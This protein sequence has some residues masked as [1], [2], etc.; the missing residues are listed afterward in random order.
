MATEVIQYNNPFDTTDIS[1]VPVEYGTSAYSLLA[2]INYDIDCYD[3]VISKNNEII[4]CDFVIEKDDIVYFAVVPKGGGGGGGKQALAIVAMVA[5]SIAAPGVGTYAGLM[6]GSMGA[7][8]AMIIGG[9]LV[10]QIGFTIVGAMIVSSVFKPK[11]PDIGSSVGMQNQESSPTYG[12]DVIGNNTAQGYPIPILYGTMKITPQYIGKYVTVNNDKQY[13]S[14]LLA[15]GDGTFDSINDIRLNGDPASNYSNVSIETR[16]GTNNQDLLPLWGETWSDVSVNKKVV[17]TSTWV[18]ATTSGDS[19]TEL[20]IGVICPQGLY[21]ANDAG[22]LDGYTVNIDI[23][24]RV[25]GGAWSP[26]ISSS[27][28]INVQ[29]L[30][31]DKTPTTFLSSIIADGTGPYDVYKRI[32]YDT[33][34][35][36][37]DNL[38]YIGEVPTLPTRSDWAK[39][40]FNGQYCWAYYSYEANY[41]YFSI[42]GAT[43]SPVRKTYFLTNLTPAQYEVRIKF[44]SLPSSGTRY[45][46]TVFFEFLQ[47]AISDDFIY[48]NTA[49]L[50]IKALATDQ[51]SGGLPRVT[52]IATRTTGTYGSLDNPAWAC[53]DL[54]MNERYGAGIPLL[55]IDFTSFS[56]WASY[57]SAQN[58]KVNIY[59]DQITNLSQAFKTIG[60]LGRGSVIQYGSTFT[61]LVDKPNIMAVQGF[62]FS[63]GNIIQNSFTES[64]LPLKERAN[65]VEVT[66]Y[67]STEDYNRISVEVSQGNYDLVTNV[68]K[69]TID[70]IG[71]T[72]RTQA[73]NQAK[74]HLNQNRY[75][76]ITATWEASI[77]S[78]HCRVGDIVN[79]AHD[80]PQWGYSGRIVSASGTTVIVDR[81]DLVLEVGKT[82]Y[83]QISNSNTDTQL[84]HKVISI[85]NNTLTLEISLSE[86]VGDYSNYSFGEVERHAKKMRILNI[87]T[88][89]ELKRKISAI[90]YNE[91]IYTDTILISAPTQISDLRTTGISISDYLN[92]SKDGTVETVVLLAWRGSSLFYNISYIKNVSGASL[93][94]LGQTRSNNIDIYGL[95]DGVE[96]IFYVDEASVR[97]TIQGK[98]VP[99]EPITAL[100][101]SESN[102]TYSLSWAYAF[103]PLDFAYFEILKDG[104]VIGKTIDNKY[105]VFYRDTKTKTFAV[106]AV[107]STGNRSTA[108][109]VIISVS[110][111]DNVANLKSFYV[112][113]ITKMIWDVVTDLRTPID[114]E[115]RM[116]TIWE[117]GYI[118]GRTPLA[119][120][121]V[122]A[123]GTYMIKVHHSYPDGT[124]LYSPLEAQL[125]I[126]NAILPKNIVATFDE[127]STGWIG[128]K[129]NVYVNGD[130][131]LELLSL[132]INDMPIIDD[133]PIFDYA[134]GIQPSGSYEIPSAHIVD[135][136]TAQICRIWMDYKAEGL[137]VT[138]RLDGILDF[139]SWVN[140][141]G[142]SSAFGLVPQISIAQNDGIFG[143]WE[144]F[145][146]GDYVGRKF[147]FRGLFYSYDQYTTCI[148]SKA[149][150]YVDMQDKLQSDN[151]ISV[152]ITGTTITYPIAFQ[153]APNVQIT[154]VNA[155]D[156]DDVKLTNETATGFDIV[157]RNGGSNVSRTI[158]WLAKGY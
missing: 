14:I 95:E 129:S 82:F 115:I 21:Y 132:N 4:D 12:W 23:E 135:V 98:S 111:L 28:L 148:L 90:E 33:K 53:L 29:Y 66:Y 30:Y 49:L 43:N 149:I 77:D 88:S 2:N 110:P 50:S 118:I 32:N 119:E 69:A 144:N 48:P 103:K 151:G 35:T 81:S 15:L 67:D 65:I 140:V 146:V 18:E 31:V 17:D 78:I 63:M 8:S 117:N 152:S 72:D 127:K 59:L 147:K 58:F 87:S 39:T 85:V 155:Q 120:Y 7:S 86:S 126:T 27:N 45:G 91:S 157:V 22:G 47:E 19:V 64:F 84:Y 9:A 37:D 158:N 123:N 125:T 114:Y 13:L 138:N 93:V 142:Y 24:Y 97:Y 25:V 40:N 113:E 104:A 75:L 99:P 57:C 55:R 107:D 10:A 141:D 150:F 105:S 36:S 83:I 92:Q 54:L 94:S 130:G 154:I 116:G 16:M 56:D 74:Y 121:V 61:A 62:L 109:S 79:V 46:S 106:M 80:V 128:T 70:L 143:A 5:L 122:S 76:T 20:C 156:G 71:C 96:Y 153:V 139:N 131:N 1:Y 52:C 137:V 145:N 44:H 42:S 134:G 112:N 3:I 11:I 73:I 100:I 101:G 51:L 6:L 136:G 34:D 124:E 41:S 89:G 26:V 102:G 68:S 60:Q 133:I 108:Q 38:V